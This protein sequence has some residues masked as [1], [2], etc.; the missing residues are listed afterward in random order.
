[1]ATG[2]KAGQLKI[3]QPQAVPIVLRWLDGAVEDW[4][5]INLIFTG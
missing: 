4:I 2:R 1:V 3:L 5:S